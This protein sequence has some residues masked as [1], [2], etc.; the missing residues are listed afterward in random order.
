MSTI[1]DSMKEVWDR[2]ASGDTDDLWGA[3]I[4]MS[5]DPIDVA[6]RIREAGQKSDKFNIPDEA[7]DEIDWLAVNGE[8]GSEQPTYR[9]AINGNPVTLATRNDPP[10]QPDRKLAYRLVFRK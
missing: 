8:D 10:Q 7:A 3:I 9:L 4:A 1:L 6:D 2:N 5:T